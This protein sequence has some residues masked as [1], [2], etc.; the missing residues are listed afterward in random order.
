M[1]KVDTGKFIRGLARKEC[2]SFVI[3]TFFLIGSNLSDLAIPKWIGLCIDMF[4]KQDFQG[5][6]ESCGYMIIV[7]IVS[8]L[9]LLVN[10][11]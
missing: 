7:V 4:N 9:L 6:G 5:I 8:F 11:G 10:C 1:Q 2:G 3:G